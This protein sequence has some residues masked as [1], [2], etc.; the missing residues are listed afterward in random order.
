MILRT[1]SSSLG[2]L[3]SDRGIVCAQV[4]ASGADRSVKKIGFFTSDAALLA[5]PET[6]GRALRQFLDAHGFSSNRAVVGVPARWTIAQ[7]KELPAVSV[8]EAKSIL[9]LAG[10]R[11]SQTDAGSLIVDYAGNLS[12]GGTRALLVG[13]LRTQLGKIEKLVDAAGL[14]LV[15]ACPAAL[16]TSAF[17]NGDHSMLYLAPGGAEMVQWEEGMPRAVRPLTAAGS[18]AVAVGSEFKRAMAL[19]GGLAGE[20]LVCDAVGMDVPASTG[21]LARIGASARAMTTESALGVKVDLAAHNGTAAGITSGAALP[22]VA[23]GLLGID[24]KRLPLDFTDSKL[25]EETTSRFGRQTWMGI[26][27]AAGL[28]IAITVLY[29]TAQSR[30]QD[31]DDLAKKLKSMDADVKSARESISRLQYGRT[32]FTE[33]PQLLE[34]IRQLTMT[35]NYD[36][37]I[38]V[39]SLNLKDSGQGQLQGKSS[40][41]K[42]NLALADRIKKSPFFINAGLVESRESGKGNEDSYTISFTVKPVP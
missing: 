20:L 31:A 9:R 28:V 11:L 40:D 34:C 27:A 35:F 13:I 16:A 3:L 17:V 41:Y 36:E 19:R 15:A 2:L 1:G 5:E 10:E 14:T 33:R 26:A 6:T 30:R 8:S 29:F 22:A 37:P 7:E 21:L 18:D 38:W 25:A 24:R 23:L 42:F 12:S 32:Y 39:T 4:V